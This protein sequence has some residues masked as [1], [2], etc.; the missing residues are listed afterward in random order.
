MHSGLSHAEEANWLAVT[1]D[2]DIFVGND[3]GYTNGIY[4]S[5]LTVWDE[6]FPKSRNWL[7]APIAWSLS[8]KSPKQIL[9]S[10]TLG[11]TMVTP[12]EITDEIPDSNDIPYSGLLS[13][14][15]THIETGISQA[16]SLG[17]VI[18][19]VGPASEADQTQKWVHEQIG[20]D[21]PKGWD[22]QLDNELV[23]Q[24]SRG[25]LWRVWSA[26]TDR[27]DL[28]VLGEAGIG[29]LSSF[30]ASAALVRF[31]SE[32]ANT[33]ETPLLITTRSANPA[34]IEG[35]WYTYVGLRAEYVANQIFTDGNTYKDSRSIDYD[36]TQIGWTAGL[37]LSWQKA[38]ITFALYD[39]NVTDDINGK[40]T[41]FGALTFGWRY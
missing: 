9:R 7:L 26:P 37:A 5:S 17:V 19:V 30:L 22:T 23:F 25:R 8:S 13:F 21:E 12:E 36:S 4:F 27:V 20:A 31:G 2:N 3:N 6:Q 11:Q 38:S 1:L 18:G 24:F 34:A 28:L 39:S 41:R 40:Y 16:D 15:H 33:F 35:D 10:Y 14:S 32:L 29:T